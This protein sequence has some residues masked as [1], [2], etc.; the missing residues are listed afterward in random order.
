MCFIGGVAQ[1]G[2]RHTCTVDVAGSTP[3]ISTRK[4][5]CSLKIENMEKMAKKVLNLWSSYKEYMM[6]A[7]VPVGD[8]GRGKLR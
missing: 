6:D 4:I 5:F 8:E 7:L 3:V 2:E 1:L